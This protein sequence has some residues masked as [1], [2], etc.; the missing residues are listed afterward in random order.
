V[1]FL[2]SCGIARGDED[3]LEVVE[4]LVQWLVCIL[5]RGPSAPAMPVKISFLGRLQPLRSKLFQYGSQILSLRIVEIYKLP[6]PVF[7]R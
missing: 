6:V 5:P 7:E 2:G 3:D 4:E 1:L